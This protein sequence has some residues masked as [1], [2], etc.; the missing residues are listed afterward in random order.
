MKNFSLYHELNKTIF[1]FTPR[2]FYGIIPPSKLGKLRF[3]E[4]ENE[5]A[6]LQKTQWSSR[7]ELEKIQLK[8][9]KQIIRH[10]YNNVSFYKKKFKKIGL[11]LD[12]IKKLDDLKKIPIL[13]KQEL[14]QNVHDFLAQN[15]KIHKIISTSGSTGKPLMIA[16]SRESIRWRDAA[17]QTLFSWSNFNP[18]SEKIMGIS[19]P[20]T[21]QEAYLTAYEV[22]FKGFKHVLSNRLHW[23]P[24]TLDSKEIIKL[25][26][27]IQKF[28]PKLIR[29]YPYIMLLLIIAKKKFDLKFPESLNFL[30]LGGEVFPQKFIQKHSGAEVFNQYGT[31]EIGQMA[32][33]CNEHSGLHVNMENTLIEIVKDGESVQSGE[34]GEV[35]ATDF[36]NFDMPLLRY[37]LEDIS[38]FE[39]GKCSCGRS[40]KRLKEIFGRKI[41]LLVTT[42]GKLINESDGIFH[43]VQDRT[44]NFIKGV[45]QF[46]VV[47]EKLNKVTIFIVPTEDYSNQIEDF[48][49]NR[50]KKLLG[51]DVEVNVKVLDKIKHGKKFQYIVSKVSKGLSG[52]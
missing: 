32:G 3:G 7:T 40:L 49:T 21:W 33:E 28:E 23:I 26:S 44:G 48:I 20:P 4:M 22:P 19:L 39:N 37:N 14:K 29:T 6:F 52:S 41:N 16:V 36:T 18:K 46:R 10:A 8:R 47:Q 15:C 2:S 1:N 50:T 35:V 42:E 24:R 13:T 12:D 43:I 5:F 34:K 27:V 9:L 25:F 11:K 45:G 31:M 17:L 38:E 30:F 51:K